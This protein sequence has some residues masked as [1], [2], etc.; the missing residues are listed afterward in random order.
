VAIVGAGHVPGIG[1]WLTDPPTDDDDLS[2]EDVLSEL[3]RTRRWENDSFVN[4]EMI[5]VWVNEVT[6]LQDNYSMNT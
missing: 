6:A 2:S 3:V 1:L 5:P 4:E